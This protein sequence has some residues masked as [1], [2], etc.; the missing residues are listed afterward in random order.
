MKILILGTDNFTA[1]A[2]HS[3]ANG[4][5]RWNIE[6][7]ITHSKAHNYKILERVAALYD[8]PFYIVDNINS[9]NS[10]DL[11]KKISPD[12]IF[13]IH[14]DRILKSKI[15]KLAKKCAVNLHPSLLPKYRG[16]TPFQ[17]VLKNGEK[18]TGITIHHITEEVDDG[19]IISQQIIHLQEDCH[20]SDLMMIM[21]Q[22]YPKIIEETLKKIM[23][24]DY[25][26]TKQHKNKLSYCGKYS[27]MD[28][29]I[30]HN[31]S[32]ITAY[33][34]IRAF[35]KPDNMARYD[36]Y[37]IYRSEIVSNENNT[38]IIGKVIKDNGLY[39]YFFDG[40]LFVK[41][42]NY[43][44]YSNNILKD[45]WGGVFV[46]NGQYDKLAVYKSIFMNFH[47][48]YTNMYS[49]ENSEYHN[50]PHNMIIYNSAFIMVVNTETYCRIFFQCMQE[51]DL[52]DIL[53]ILYY[54]F[55]KTMIIEQV[56]KKSN[57]MQENIIKN[58]GYR[59]YGRLKRL[60][61]QVSK[62]DMPATIDEN[63]VFANTKDIDSIIALHSSI[64]DKYIDRELTYNN[65]TALI[66]KNNVFIY[67]SNN[68]ILGC[69]IYE[70]RGRFFHLKYW[71]TDK[72]N[73]KYKKGIG[74]ALLNKLY[75]IAG[76]SNYIEVWC[77]TDNTTALN[78]YTKYNFKED[79][80][81]CDIFI[82][83]KM[84]LC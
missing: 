39:L 4:D 5:K 21:I 10:Y 14:F 13:S 12:V 72:N 43:S 82:T 54:S 29:I 63:I 69:I 6:A 44:L 61:K 24:N 3:I 84:L 9:E 65:M 73:I 30:N 71:F 51:E 31:D 26:G 49:I 62:L 57:I 15:F 35:S 53:S 50:H 41:N 34:K 33:N 19:N 76:S 79:G 70:K 32:V 74:K 16:M 55:K 83:N 48:K 56:Y 20:L 59:L 7:V 40:I 2:L 42:G 18:K 78:I 28:Y 58:T 68:Q 1:T 67:K 75:K 38:D 37:M 45:R 22:K 27:E 80:L 8:I 60:S 52:S 25:E 23:D 64:F 46:I 17:S 81:K 36:E 11:I 47:A 66:K 77:K